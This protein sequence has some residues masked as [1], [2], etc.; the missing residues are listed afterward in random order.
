MRF[1]SLGSGSKGNASLIQSG[2]TLLMVDNGFSLKETHRRLERL[3]VHASDITAILVTHEHGDHINGVGRLAKKYAIPV[4]ASHG[5]ASMFK[6]KQQPEQLNCFNTDQRFSINDIQVSPILVPHDAK[7]PTQFVFNAAGSQFAIMTDFGSITQHIIDELTGCDAL[8]L[9]CNYDNDML[10]AGPYPESLKRR[11]SGDW[12]HLSNDQAVYL[13]NKLDV[14]QLQHLA[15][16]HS[17]E[18]NNHHDLILDRLSQGTHCDRAWLKIIDQE[19]G[20]DWQTV[21]PSN[22]IKETYHA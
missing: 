8:L 7:E 14:R 19:N 4:W 10:M 18:K 13:L 3:D 9:E 20:L 21:L 1:A 5:T 11:V 6:L 17:S 12:G 22:T 16:A 15:L 2:E